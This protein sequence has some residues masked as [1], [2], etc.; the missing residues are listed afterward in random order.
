MSSIYTIVI[1]GSI[2]ISQSIKI[3]Y[4]EQKIKNLENKIKSL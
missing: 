2:L 4:L 3:L 1:F